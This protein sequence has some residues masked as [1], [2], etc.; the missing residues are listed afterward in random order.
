M[1]RKANIF[2]SPQSVLKEGFFM[3]LLRC[4]S[5]FYAMSPFKHSVFFLHQ[6]VVERGG[7]A[8]KV[9]KVLKLMESCVHA[10]TMDE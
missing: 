1:V 6:D 5:N 4:Q 2:P 10:E 7:G 8:V 9:T 3:P